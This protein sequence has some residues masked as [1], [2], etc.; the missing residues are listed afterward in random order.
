MDILITSLTENTITIPIN[1]LFWGSVFAFILHVFEESV[2]PE[3]FVEKVKRLYFPDFD[4][5]KF[6]YFNGILLIIN[7][8]AVVLFE[9]LQ[10]IWIIF[11]LSLLFERVINGLYHLIETIITKKYSRK[12]YYSYYLAT[13]SRIIT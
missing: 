13:I 7:I 10:G 2:I 12:R 1:L 6:F 5:H 3:V 9:S 8:C 4:W 11:P